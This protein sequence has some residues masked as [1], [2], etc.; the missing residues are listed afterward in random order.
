MF[1]TSIT[2]LRVCVALSQVT[3]AVPKAPVT[4]PGVSFEPLKFAVKVVVCALAAPAI[5][6]T[7]TAA[8]TIVNTRRIRALLDLA[9]L[10]STN[11]ATV[12]EASDANNIR[13]C[14]CDGTEGYAP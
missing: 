9:S 5:P 13:V 8:P 7:I 6:S 1:H 11:R 14:S 10:E 4:T 2:Q 3:V 12:G